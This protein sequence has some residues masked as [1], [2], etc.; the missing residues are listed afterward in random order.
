MLAYERRHGTERLI[1]AL[2]LG[3]RT[4]R[5]QLP[6]WAIGARPLLSTLADAAQPGHGE[7]LLRR[8]EGVI[9]TSD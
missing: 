4:Q 2:N 7:L 3:T 9:L 6:D 8:N 5:L 1:V